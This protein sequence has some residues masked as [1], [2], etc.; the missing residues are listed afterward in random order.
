ML[1]DDVDSIQEQHVIPNDAGIHMCTLPPLVVPTS[2]FNDES[3]G[4][5]GKSGHVLRY[6]R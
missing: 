2:L 5:F 4:K 6:V 3:D 1:R